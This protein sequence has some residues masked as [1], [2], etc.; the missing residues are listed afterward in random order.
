MKKNK[1]TILWD[2]SKLAKH[3]DNRADYNYDSVSKVIERIKKKIRKKKLTV[4]DIGA[5]TGK[6][7]K[8]LIKKKC[9]VYAIEP[10]DN[11][12]KIGKKNFG[13]NCFWIKGF[14]ENTS[15]KEKVDCVFFGSSFNVVNYKKTISELKKI[16]FKNGYVVIMWNHRELSNIIQKKIEKVIFQIIPNY[17][18]GKRRSDWSK[19]FKN[20]IFF[21]KF[22]KINKKFTVTISKKNFVDAWK[23]HAT[24][25]RQTSKKNFNL[26]IKRIYK[27]LEAYKHN[28]IRIPYRT[29]IYCIKTA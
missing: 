16:I 17:D 24:L 28:S 26:I 14:A 8:I 19:I 27:I 5:G 1:N 4:A 18:Y 3:Y 20:E 6:L 12:R 21:D 11:M 2:Y 23:S 15:L 25:K 29:V 22:I 10:N 7:T 13:K 9:K